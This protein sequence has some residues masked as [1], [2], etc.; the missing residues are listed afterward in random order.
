MASSGGSSRPPLPL[1][2]VRGALIA[3]PAPNTSE[4]ENFEARFKANLIFTA[5]L[6]APGYLKQ[7]RRALLPGLRHELLE[8]DRYL[9]ARGYNVTEK[10]QDRRQHLV[11]AIEVLKKLTQGEEEEEERGRRVLLGV[12]GPY[13][14]KLVVKESEGPCELVEKEAGMV[15]VTSEVCCALDEL[16]GCDRW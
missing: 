12:K 9:F 14:P 8:F 1:S 15:D 13:E 10:D 6:L 7:A 4:Y 5:H 3:I 16:M 2:Y 11:R